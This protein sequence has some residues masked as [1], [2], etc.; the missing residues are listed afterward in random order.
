MTEVTP[1][2]NPPNFI[3]TCGSGDPDV[4]ISNLTSRVGYD[5]VL[6]DCK[7]FRDLCAIEDEQQQ[8][9][10]SHGV[11]QKTLI[12]LDEYEHINQNHLIGW[13]MLCRVRNI[14]TLLKHVGVYDDV[15]ILLRVNCERLMIED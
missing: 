8:Q 9:Y 5:R 2:R 4:V 14:S 13:L 7:T 1:T 12:V 3:A 10:D 15:P 6:Y 11:S